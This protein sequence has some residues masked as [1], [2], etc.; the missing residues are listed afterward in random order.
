MITFV[1]AGPGA[2]DLITVRGLRLIREADVVI[3]AGSLVNPELLKEVKESCKVY[4]SSVMTLPELVDVMAEAEEQKLRVVRLH[5]GDRRKSP[6]GVA[7]LKFDR[8][9][10]P[11]IASVIGCG[12][13]FRG[14][15]ACSAAG[16]HKRFGLQNFF[17]APVEPEPHHKPAFA[18]LVFGVKQRVAVGIGLCNTA[19]RK[20][21]R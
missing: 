12:K 7:G 19:E 18:R 4:D 1:G 15:F 9:E 13:V 5:T 17:S 20:T 11:V 10:Q 6:A 8:R 2:V 16:L 14:A 3:Y 21:A